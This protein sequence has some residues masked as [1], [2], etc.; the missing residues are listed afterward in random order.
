MKE[1]YVHKIRSFLGKQQ[2]SR[3]KIFARKL[4]KRNVQYAVLGD[5]I[6]VYPE[7]H[8]YEGLREQEIRR[9]QYENKFRNSFLVSHAQA[10][11]VDHVAFARAQTNVD[12]S[13]LNN[14]ALSLLA[15]I[16]MKVF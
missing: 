2:S 13:A 8:N 5:L 12:I 15:D 9:E 1:E 16:D 4:V 10:Q 11:Q 6:R 7:L 14:V 3:R